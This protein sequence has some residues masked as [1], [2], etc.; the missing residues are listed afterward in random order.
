VLVVVYGWSAMM[1][2]MIIGVGLLIAAAWMFSGAGVV[3]A[4]VGG[5]QWYGR[6][7]WRGMV[8]LAEIAGGDRK[9]LVRPMVVGAT[10][11]F[12]L[13]LVAFVMPFPTHLSAPAVVRYPSECSVRCQVD[14]FVEAVHVES[15]QR[16]RAGD[17]LLELR[18][19]DLIKDLRS[20]GMQIR[21][22]E[23]RQ[24]AAIDSLDATSEQVEA[25]NM[26]SLLRRQRHL[27]SR[28]ARLR[29][30]SHAD[31]RVEGRDLGQLSGSFVRQGDRLMQIVSDDRKEVVL[32]I[33][34]AGI[35]RTRLR[36]DHSVRFA[37][38]GIATF[39]S[40]L[41]R[42]HPRATD[43]VPSAA[44]AATSGGPMAVRSDP[45]S[46]DESRVKLVEPH[47]EAISILEPTV[48]SGVPAGMI[49]QARIG[50]RSDPL[51]SRLRT[52]L[53]RWWYDAEAALS[54][55]TDSHR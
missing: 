50:Y 12:C 54:R 39:E 34:Q 46:G 2:R 19:D 48:A 38:A 17:L 45:D 47:F 37:S 13:G 36:K 51:A 26:Q 14:G 30:F 32:M 16:V 20:V 15:G 27:E 21:A 11:A 1:W 24:L 4:I 31:G 35:R 42:I 29:L 6:P 3:I 22:S 43:R 55:K 40:S 28:V 53:Y 23:L 25:E 10:W 49:L 41:T 8:G 33:D 52:T 5:A 7:L 9:R 18:N 44:L